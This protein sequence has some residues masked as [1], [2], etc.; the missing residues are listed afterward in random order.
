MTSMNFPIASSSKVAASPSLEEAQSSSASPATWRRWVAVGAGI[1]IE[2]HGDDLLVTAVSVRFGKL[3]SLQELRIPSIAQRPASDW[4]SEYADIL[5]RLEL[6]HLAANLVLPR[7]AATVRVL[8]LP[9]LSPKEIEAAVGFQIDSLHPY[10]DDPVVHAWARLNPAGAVLVAIARE[11]TARFW[12]DLFAEAGIS[13][14]SMTVGPAC[15]YSA[16]RLW[17]QP[18]APQFVALEECESEVEYYGESPSR[19]LLSHVLP[20]VPAGSQQP[21]RT[22]VFLR[23]ELRLDPEA[24]CLRLRDLLPQPPSSNGVWGGPPGP[25][26]TPWSRISRPFQRLRRTPHSLQLSSAPAADAAL[27]TADAPSLSTEASE[28]PVREL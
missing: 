5:K 19:A 2:C 12:A 15:I 25:R 23:S 24:P 8:P 4:G 20:T 18:P 22:Q 28:P 11:E 10:A 16:F 13:L 6:G 1:G 27:D 17:S 3:T 14:T 9:P 21:E 26:A 7:D